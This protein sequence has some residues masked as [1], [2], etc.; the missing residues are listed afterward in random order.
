MNCIYIPITPA[1]AKP[2]N[3]SA[4][5]RKATEKNKLYQLTELNFEILYFTCSYTFTQ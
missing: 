4:D 5:K 1:K 2:Y 3:I